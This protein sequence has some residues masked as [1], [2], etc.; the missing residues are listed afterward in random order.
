MLKAGELSNALKYVEDS[1]NEALLAAG[2]V[3]EVEFKDAWP[4]KRLFLAGALPEPLIQHYEQGEQVWQQMQAMNIGSS[5]DWSKY[6]LGSLV[7]Q[8]LDIADPSIRDMYS[9]LGHDLY[10]E[11]AILAILTYLYQGSRFG[12]LL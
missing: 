9:R 11:D 7:D 2:R 5:S 12:R 6:H 4:M 10:G 3:D 1:E 8:I